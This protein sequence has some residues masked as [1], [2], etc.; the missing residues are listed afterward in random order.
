[1]AARRVEERYRSNAPVTTVR[2]LHHSFLPGS[3][4]TNLAKRD[5]KRNEF[6]QFFMKTG[7]IGQASGS[8]YL[9]MANTKIICGIYGPRQIPKME[10]SE[11][12][13]LQ[14]D[15]KFATFA[16]SRR[17]RRKYTADKEEK[18]FSMLMV[19]AL[20]SSLILEKYP[21]SVIDCYVIVLENDGGALNG[22]ITCA[23]MALANAGIEMY[24]L[25]AAASIGL[26]PL[27]GEILLDPTEAEEIEYKKGGKKGGGVV[28]IGFMPGMNEITQIWQS[29]QIPQEKW[30]L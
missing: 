20:E 14:C 11:K 29:G 15:F 24:D 22:A 19:Q 3:Q 28:T 13:K 30:L 10:F 5:R 16:E 8:A 9:E 25:V 27:N 17:E 7:I 26:N 21:K 4:A 6:R 1:M 2:P 18:E 23:S 12:A